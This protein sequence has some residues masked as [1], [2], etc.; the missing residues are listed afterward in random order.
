VACWSSQ[1]RGKGRS[2]VA[3]VDGGTWVWLAIGIELI[4]YVPY[5]G[6]PQLIRYSLDLVIVSA[7][8]QVAVV[9]GCMFRAG[10]LYVTDRLRGLASP[11]EAT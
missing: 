4:A 10:Q 7:L 1:R 8:F 3:T 6:E 11:G 9:G 2:S 5:T